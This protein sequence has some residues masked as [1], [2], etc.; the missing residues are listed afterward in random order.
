MA[1]QLKITL[2][3]STIGRP[4]TQEAVVRGLGLK[5]LN[6]SVVLK[7]SEAVRG[8]VRKVSHLLKVERAE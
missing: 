5:K 1:K 6:R 2:V 3:R 8:M 4:H 7:D